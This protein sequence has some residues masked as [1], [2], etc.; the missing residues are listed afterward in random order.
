MYCV[1][2][3]VL[4]GVDGVCRISGV[5]ERKIRGDL[6]EYYILKPV[7]QENSTIF[8]PKN[9]EALR[10]KMRRILSVEEI[11]KLIKAMPDESTVWIENE[12]MRRVRYK[13]ILDKGDRMELIGLI[14]TLYLQSQSLKEKGKKLH[15]ID[16]RF[17]KDAEKTL[18]EEFAHVLNIEREHVLPFIMDQIE[19]NEKNAEH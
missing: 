8:V 17:M 5:M 1:N 16:D 7:Y 11:Y 15:M 13:E 6:C 14:K 2:D 3:M 9:N 10:M 19:V 4:Y 18:Y 12:N